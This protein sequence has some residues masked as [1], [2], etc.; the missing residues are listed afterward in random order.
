MQQ[1]NE[2]F[3]I[4]HK[5]KA[6]RSDIITLARTC[7]KK[8]KTYILPVEGSVGKRNWGAI[9]QSLLYKLNIIQKFHF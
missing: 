1:I 4:H 6:K 2:L 5:N 8:M 3:Q 7:G 9:W